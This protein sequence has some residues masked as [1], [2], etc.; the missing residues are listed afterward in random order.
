MPQYTAKTEITTDRGEK[1]TASKSGQYNEVFNVRQEVDDATAFHTLLKGGDSIGQ[2]TI[3]ECKSLIIKNSGDVGAEIQIQTETWSDATPDTNGGVVYKSYLIGANDYIYFPNFRQLSYN[4]DTSAGNAYVVDNKLPEKVNPSLMYVDSG[5]NLG[6]KIED[7]HTSITVEDAAPFKVG[8]LIQVGITADTATR[9][10]VMRVTAKTAEDGET[11]LSV[12]RALYGTSKAD[13]D[14][15]TN[16]NFGAVDGASVFFPIFNIFSNSSFYNGLAKPS[17]DANG[18]FEIT[19]MFGYG[20]YADLVADGIVAGSFSCKFY[21]AGYQGLGLSNVKLGDS[22]GLTV[23]TA[24]QFTI[25]VDGGSAY[26]LDFTTDSSDTSFRNVLKKIQDVFDAQYYTTSSNLFEKRVFVGLDKGGD[27]VFTSGQHLTTSAIALGDSSGGD[28]DWWGVG[29]IPAVASVKGAVEARLPD[30][31]IYDVKTGVL[32]PNKSK[33][34]YDNG[35]GNILGACTGKINY[36]T[37]A[38]LLQNAPPMAD[39]AFNVAYGSAH[40]GGNEFSAATGNSLLEIGARSCNSKINT[41]I[42][43]IGLN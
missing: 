2:S 42:E 28:T 41:T 17:T 43:I 7:S 34:A 27:V 6:A 18:N 24:Y 39:F 10:E 26:D 8:D 1:L 36:E 38:L 23:S 32:K 5:I 12:D 22:T 35:H 21:E 29:R 3:Q 9:I 4:A 15:Q 37:G 20:R 19:T 25:A 11:T 13:G 31:E 33:F 16:A 30:D 14:N 40:A